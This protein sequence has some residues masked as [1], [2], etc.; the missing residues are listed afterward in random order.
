VALVNSRV[1]GN[2][3]VLDTIELDAKINIPAKDNIK[4]I[5]FNNTMVKDSKLVDIAE[6]NT[7]LDMLVNNIV[8]NKNR[9][10]V[11]DR[12][13]SIIDIELSSIDIGVTVF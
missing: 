13:V 6:V 12:A 8:L 11:V 7:K 10:T 5:E 1:V 3:R 9:D 2:D 4:L